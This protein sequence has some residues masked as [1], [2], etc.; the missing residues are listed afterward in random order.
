MSDM[1]F[2]TDAVANIAAYV[3]II[4]GGNFHVA[5]IMAD[6]MEKSL[7][8]GEK[9]WVAAVEKVKPLIRDILIAYYSG[10]NHHLPTIIARHVDGEVI[11]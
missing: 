6:M 10:E 7:A 11:Q 2:A 1:D 3:A 5:E 9:D 4:N 8:V